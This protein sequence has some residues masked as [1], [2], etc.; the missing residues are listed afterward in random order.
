MASVT[1]S[2]SGSYCPLTGVG[3]VYKFP[4]LSCCVG[5]DGLDLRQIV[6]SA[7]NVVEGAAAKATELGVLID[8]RVL[9]YLSLIHI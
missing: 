9:T 1:V 3:G 5:G 2:Q 6:H 8:R 4:H 7:R